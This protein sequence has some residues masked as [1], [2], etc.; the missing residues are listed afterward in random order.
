MGKQWNT[1]KWDGIICAVTSKDEKVKA[2][3]SMSFLC[4]NVSSVEVAS[5]RN[6]HKEI[7]SGFTLYYFSRLKMI[8]RSLH[9]PI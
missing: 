1:D 3:I 8:F 9:I 7:S 2:Q 5:Q 4:S 6:A